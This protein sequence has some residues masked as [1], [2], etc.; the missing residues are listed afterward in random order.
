MNSFIS[1][2]PVIEIELPRRM[3]SWHTGCVTF[4]E[5]A[6]GP[7]LYEP[8]EGY[9]LAGAECDTEFKDLFKEIER[10]GTHRKSIGKVTPADLD[11]HW[12]D[13]GGVR[14]MIHRQ[15]LFILE[16]K[17]ESE[18]HLPRAL[19]IL[20]Q[21]DRAITASPELVPDIEFSFIVKDLPDEAHAH[22]TYWALSKLQ[23]DKEAWLMPDF[24]FW[25]W[26]LDLVGAYEQIRV[27]GIQNQVAWEKRIPKVL[28]RGALKTNKDVRGALYRV[29]RSKEWADVE[30]VKW[31][32]RT[33]VSAG[34]AASALSMVDHCNYK[35]LVHTEGRSYSGRGKYLLN[36]GS[37]VITHKSQWM[38]PHHAVYINAGLEQ[39]VVEVERDFSDLEEK[40]LGLL[41]EPNLAHKIATNGQKTFRDRHLTPAAQACYWRKLFHAWANVSFQPKPFETVDGRARL[42]GVPFE[43]F[44]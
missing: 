10:S 37:V 18:Y 7:G 38:E 15:K 1:V 40:V 34:S 22:H 31:K 23:V 8:F 14:A 2:L 12:I 9:A 17:L 41:K 28:W 43:T 42:R 13:D 27:E 35:F 11:L 26:P 5:T 16:S 24:G 21:I 20:H 3:N 30:E 44:V 33:K 25:T 19:S 36:C 29:T 6:W 32:S 4:V 39:N